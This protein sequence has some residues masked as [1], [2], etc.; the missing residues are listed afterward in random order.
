MNRIIKITMLSATLLFVPAYAQVTSKEQHPAE[1]PT[2]GVAHPVGPVLAA[3]AT[4]TRK[5]ADC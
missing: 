4:C 2:I 5:D 3:T 1:H